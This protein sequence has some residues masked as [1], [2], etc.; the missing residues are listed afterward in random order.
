MQVKVK[1]GNPQRRAFSVFRRGLPTGKVS[2]WLLPVVALAAVAVMFILA[3]V[4]ERYLFPDMS[5]GWRHALLTARSAIV[6]AAGAAILY[7][8]M[9]RQ[10]QRLSR[11]A[12]QLTRLLE[13]YQRKPS[14]G[15]RFEN[16]HLLHCRDVL[17]CRRTRC[18]MYEAPGER[19][20]QKL[21][22]NHAADDRL[23]PEVEIEQCYQ[24]AVYRKSCPDK[25]YELGES[26]N[27]LMYLLEQES[28]QVGRMRAQMV[29]KEK[30][31]AIGQMAAGIAHEV[32]N[33]LSSISAVVQML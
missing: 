28:G 23:C 21:A 15:L 20:W 16:P 33:P 10:Q 26:F 18:A 2:R 17:D 27:N 7:L 8:W 12:E 9:R 5:T 14:T 31:V 4:I 32:C 3:D 6:T 13:S 11:T 25:L 24:C 19:C 1:L 22:L 30:M 29:E